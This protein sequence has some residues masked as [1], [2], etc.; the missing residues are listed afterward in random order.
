MLQ[1]LHT[2]FRTMRSQIATTAKRNS[3]SNSLNTIAEPAVK[4]FVVN[5]QMIEDR[6]PLGVGTTLSVSA[7][8]AVR[9]LVI[10]NPFFPLPAVPTQG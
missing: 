7:L 5:V 8:I 2:G 3:M 4:V 6:C 9:N 1:D 10:Y